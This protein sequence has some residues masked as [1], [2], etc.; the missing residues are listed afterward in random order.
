MTGSAC[1]GAGGTETFFIGALNIVGNYK[2]FWISNDKSSTTTTFLFNEQRNPDS[3]G[4]AA[5]RSTVFLLFKDQIFNFYGAELGGGGR[6]GRVCMK[7]GGCSNGDSYLA[8]AAFTRVNRMK[9]IGAN[10]SNTLKNGSVNG[11]F[12]EGQYL[13]AI[14][15]AYEYDNDGGG[16]NESQMYI[17]NG[18]YYSGTLDNNVRSTDSDGGIMRTVLAYSAR[19]ALPDDCPNDS[20]GCS[21]YYED[22]T[23]DAN[24]KW[25][26][27]MSIALPQNSAVTGSANCG[28]SSIEMDCTLPYNIFVPSMKAIPYMRT[29]PNGDLYILRN[30]C[31]VTTICRNGNGTCDFRTARQTCPIGSEVPQVWMLPQGTTGSPKGAAD[32][33]LVA[34]NGTTGKTNM[35][36]NTGS[37]GTGP[38]KCQSNTHLSLLEFVGTY[39]SNVW[40]VD[41]NSG[42]CTGGA[43]CT[44]GLTPAETQF[45][46]VNIPGIDGTATNQRIFTHVTMNDAG[47][48]WLVIV[49][50]DGSSAMK[51]YRTANDQN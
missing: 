31:S 5:Y 24:D 36:A 46:M 48:D 2:S 23:P 10:N 14:N 25:S 40:R 19:T 27:Y 28:T 18:G 8:G 49:T 45:S 1:T 11:L 34:E 7:S 37:C 33:V 29:A 26:N 13:N 51:I 4:G 9:R 44:T 35:A 6:G 47:K 30:A 20:R 39:S 42:T 50:R 43:A 22:V 3:G 21:T 41:F 16:S 12:G 15:V 32:W 38:N 17:A